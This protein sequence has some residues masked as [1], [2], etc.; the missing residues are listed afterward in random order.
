[1]E[2]GSLESLPIEI[3]SKYTIEDVVKCG[4]RHKRILIDYYSIRRV[5]K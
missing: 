1:M 2:D 3:K 4:E 5:A